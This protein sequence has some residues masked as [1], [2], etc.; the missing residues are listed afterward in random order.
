MN[1]E[2]Y[3]LIDTL[4]EEK[5]KVVELTNEEAKIL[6]YAYLLNNTS[7]KYICN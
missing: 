1:L 6:N 7:F 4:T 5:I 3:T 2:T